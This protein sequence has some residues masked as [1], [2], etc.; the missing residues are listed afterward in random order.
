MRKIIQY[1][2]HTWGH[3]LSFWKIDNL[4]KKL[5]EYGPTFL[6]IVI[7]V[8]LIEHFGLPVLFYY[9]GNNVHDFFY[10]LIPTPLFICLHFITAPLI[11]LIY[12]KLKKT[13]PTIKISEFYRNT[14]KLL[15]SISIAQ[16]IPL[17]ITPL[18]TQYFSPQDFGIYGLYVSL[19]YI[20]G[21]IGSAK[22]D[23]AIMLPKK[24]LTH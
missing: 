18:L 6:I 21:T 15:T 7:L 17:L 16:L 19:C 12:I 1:I 8:E 13:R 2:K 5:V 20:F 4:K 11:F 10:A 14:L 22:Y 3:K 24:R 9:L 23:V